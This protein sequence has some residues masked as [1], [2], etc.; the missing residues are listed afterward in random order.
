MQNHGK[1]QSLDQHLVPYP[2]SWDKEREHAASSPPQSFLKQFRE[3]V[4]GALK[5]G[6]ER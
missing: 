1:A 5:G 3:V 4:I 6:R 2:P